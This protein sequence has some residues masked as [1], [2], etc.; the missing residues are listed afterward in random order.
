MPHSA[1]CND[2]EQA[3]LAREPLDLEG[4]DGLAAAMDSSHSLCR[5][6]YRNLIDFDEVHKG[7]HC[8]AWEQPDLFAAELRA[9]FKSL[10]ELATSRQRGKWR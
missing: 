8:A 6:A 3:R 2:H 5:R 9:A 1:H 10:R 4:L 7:G